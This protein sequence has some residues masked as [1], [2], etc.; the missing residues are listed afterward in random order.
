M[1]CGA[2]V[3]SALCARNNRCII[4]FQS[5]LG[6]ICID[7]LSSQL[8]S[9]IRC[10]NIW[11]KNI[12]FSR[13]LVYLFFFF[14][15]FFL[16]VIVYCI[17]TQFFCYDTTFLVSLLP[18]QSYICNRSRLRESKKNEQDNADSTRISNDVN[19]E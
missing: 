14:F 13:K 12:F 6:V 7:L 9:T 4:R 19:L 18:M 17:C 2:S 11:R 15:L 3:T 1:R 16:V 10:K 5:G 8:I